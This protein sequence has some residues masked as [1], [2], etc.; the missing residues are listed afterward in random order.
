MAVS[1]VMVCRVEIPFTLEF[2]DNIIDI[3]LADEMKRHNVPPGVTPEVTTGDFQKV[4]LYRWVG[5]AGLP[6][7]GKITP[8]GARWNN[9]TVYPD[10][11]IHVPGL[12]Y[13][14]E[15]QA[16]EMALDLLAAVM[17]V[18]CFETGQT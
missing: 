13:L 7:P 3:V 18:R 12:G 16:E 6:K 1:A 9:C 17:R 10:N 5:I 14:S 2:P 11:V 15:E 4:Y 8:A